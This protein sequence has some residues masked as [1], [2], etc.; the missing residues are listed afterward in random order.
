M[1]RKIALTLCLSLLTALVAHAEPVLQS[2]SFSK[3]Y[4][5]QGFDSNDNVQF[6]GEGS[7]RNTCYRPAPTSFQVDQDKKV[8]TVGPAAYEYGGICLQVILPFERVVDLGI[9]KPGTYTVLQQP[10]GDKLGEINVAQ[11]RTDSA[12]DY[13]YAPVS[14]AFF[15]QKGDVVQVVLTGNFMTN[16][17]SLDHVKVHVDKEAL[18]LQPI[19]KLEDRNG[20]LRGRFPYSKVVEIHNVPKNRYLLHVRSLDGKAFNSLVDVI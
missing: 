18:V 1:T 10:A 6:V 8:I 5:P 14:Q 15:K 11:A 16:C 13:L 9:L 2:T 20:C 4:S 19:A 12:D 3:I 17:M 7:F